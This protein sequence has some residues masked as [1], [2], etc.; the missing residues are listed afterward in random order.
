[1][2]PAVSRS[3]VVLSAL[4]LLGT[5]VYFQV[6]GNHGQPIDIVIPN[7]FTGEV[8]LI[9]D[10]NAAPIPLYL[11][12]YLL[13]IPP[14]GILRVK[15]L[16]PFD[17]YHQQTIRFMNGTMIAQTIRPDDSPDDVAIRGV[18]SMQSGQ[19]HSLSFFV[20]TAANYTEH[21][22]KFSLTGR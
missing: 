22:Q 17:H 12:R 4:V 14:S 2:K 9:Q 18:M 21:L 6:A 5:L 1:M 19:E 7:L 16:Q 8:Q 15:S 3:L 11:N 13:I 20:G 10:D